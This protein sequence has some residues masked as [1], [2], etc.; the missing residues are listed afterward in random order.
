ME[1]S[2]FEHYAARIA[3]GAFWALVI[4]ST[5]AAFYGVFNPIGA[6]PSEKTPATPMS[7]LSMAPWILLGAAFGLNSLRK[8]PWSFKTF[9]RVFLISQPLMQYALGPSFWAKPLWFAPQTTTIFWAFAVMTGARMLFER[10][11]PEEAF[12]ESPPAQKIEWSLA[13][14]GGVILIAGILFGVWAIFKGIA[15][16]PEYSNMMQAVIALP[17]VAYLFVRHLQLQRKGARHD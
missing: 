3:M 8:N 1:K 6:A 7:A 15:T 11:H 5:L 9:W 10:L 14:L 16:H 2:K 13:S 12:D 4:G 17:Y